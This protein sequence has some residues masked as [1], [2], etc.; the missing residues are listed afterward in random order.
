MTITVHLTNNLSSEQEAW[1]AKTIGP[2]LFYLHNAIG[3][4]G[5]VAKQE[6]TPGMVYK[7]WTLTF[8]DDRYAT[9]FLIKYPQGVYND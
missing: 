1:L 8:E 5:W 2:R 7:R 3:G 4:E 6:W 9:F